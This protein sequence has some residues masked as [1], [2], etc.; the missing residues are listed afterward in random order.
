MTDMSIPARWLI[1]EYEVI[2]S[3][4][5]YYA[6]DDSVEADLGPWGSVYVQPI[7]TLK[8]VMDAGAAMRVTSS[9]YADFGRWWL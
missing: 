1:A 3:D 2:A 9:D 4:Y 6:R 7:F 8:S 5:E